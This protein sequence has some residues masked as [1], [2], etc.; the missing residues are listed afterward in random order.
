MIMIK[1]TMLNESLRREKYSGN[2][3]NNYDV[4]EQ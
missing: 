3:D 1:T 4:Y 2:I